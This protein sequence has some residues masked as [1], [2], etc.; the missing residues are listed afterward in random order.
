MTGENRG[1]ESRERG[2]T[3]VF[4]ALAVTA[5]LSVVALAIDVGMLLNSRSEAQRAADAAAMAGA[6]K[7]I[8][9]PTNA[10]LAED[11]AI[12]FGEMNNVMDQ[13]ADILPG[14]V[15]VDL[16]IGRVTVRVRRE[17]DRGNAVGTWF[18]NVFGVSS[19]DVGAVAAAQVG[20]ASAA[21]CVKPWAIADAWDDADGDEVYDPGELYQADLTGWGTNYRD[22]GE[23]G[24]GQM[25]DGFGI[26]Y[27]D[28]RGRQ[29]R[30]AEGDPD[31]T[32]VSGWYFPW[33]IPQPP[34]GVCSG[35]PGGQGG[36]CYEWSISHCHP[37]IIQL[38]AV[39][40]VENGRM[41]GPMNKGINDLIAQD[42]D[43]VWDPSTNTVT[44]SVSSN[45]EGSPRIVVVPFY[46]PTLFPLGPGKEDIV[47]NNFGE[48]FIEGKVGN[49]IVGRFMG[50]A[51]GVGGDPGPTVPGLQFV[52]IVE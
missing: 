4:V 52:Q 39:Y 32:V 41:V 21:T 28:D 5:L 27:D 50:Y 3:I 47:F 46:D 11:T 38:G 36:S 17:A 30:I 15:D 42:P 1:K 22:T 48:I 51:V 2:A 49:D 34:G 23:P 12:E 14:D 45:W 25:P 18:A 40:K 43:A 20:Q 26:A 19:A 9:E 6:G 33:D 16:G 37:Q 10:T 8:P 13:F 35:G 7:L 29:I 24:E 44:G 31:E